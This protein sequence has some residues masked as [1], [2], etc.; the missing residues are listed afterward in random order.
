MQDK[1]DPFETFN[2]LVK[3]WWKIV[4]VAAMGGLL[5]LTV[6][7]IMPPVYQAEAV[8]HASIDFTEINFE[9]L[10]DQNG[11]P[12]KFTQYDE[13]LALQIV[14]RAVIAEQ[15]KA[16]AYAVSLDSEIDQRTFERDHQIQRYNAQ[17]VLRYRHA[18]PEVARA[19]VNY[20]AEDSFERIKQD[21]ASGT[22]ESFV[23]VDWDSKASTPQT[24]TYRNRNTL[25]LTGT[26][27]GFVAGV[28][29]V[30]FR[31]R[32]GVQV[33]EKAS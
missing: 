8:F 4:L 15:D 33:Q 18:D 28:I 24:P 22:A 31:G 27:I 1:F 23:L 26:L 16:F 32:F 19:I 14:Q 21:Q 25:V 9:N 29:G 17:W 3:G 10:V 5:G 6:S 20:W 11:E 13:D 2:T 7:F 30:D 12:A